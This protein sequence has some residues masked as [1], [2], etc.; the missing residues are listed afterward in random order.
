M[1][2]IQ[3]CSDS[4]GIGLEIAPL[5]IQIVVNEMGITEEFNHEPLATQT[6]ASMRS[7]FTCFFD[8]I[9]SFFRQKQALASLS[10]E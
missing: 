5:D 4:H 6:W 10:T 8:W 9:R 2:L 3:V 1:A 7:H